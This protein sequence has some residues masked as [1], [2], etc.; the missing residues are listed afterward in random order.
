MNEKITLQ[1][2][3]ELFA[4]TNDISKKKSD[5]FL[6]HLFDAISE[7]LAK[8]GLVK[9][10]G[11]GTFKLVEVGERESI[12]VSTGE[13]VLIPGYKKVNFIPDELFANM[14]NSDAKGI[15]DDTSDLG[16]EDGDAD[17][18]DVLSDLDD[19]ISEEVE[20]PEQVE[21]A[22]DD[23]SGIDLLIST[24]ESV[25]GVKEDLWKARNVAATMRAKAEHAISQAKS[26]ESEVLRLEKLIELLEKK[27][28]GMDV[29]VGDVVVPLA[30][31][32]KEDVSTEGLNEEVN[33]CDEMR[34]DEVPED[35]QLQN[36]DDE[37]D[38]NL[39]EDN[40]NKKKSKIIIFILLIVLLLLGG[41]AYWYIHSD[42]GNGEFVDDVEIKTVDEPKMITPVA[43]SLEVDTFT[44]AVDSFEAKLSDDSLVVMEEQK[45]VEVDSLTSANNRKLAISDN[46]TKPASSVK[47]DKYILKEGETLTMLARR[48]YGSA[49]SVMAIINAN[50]FT[51]PNNVHVGAKVI[52]P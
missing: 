8:D 26:A 22:S 5:V 33:G 31:E 10:K 12:S 13:R 18:N 29:G 17:S 27:S 37:L 35:N 7:G 21:V 15:V 24:P 34:V 46:S 39:D 36:R 42:K 45:D 9:I 1:A 23:F 51:D 52:L 30:S 48:F 40:S 44:H 4:N 6:R 3:A 14:I 20:T 32:V 50:N 38:D 11:W 43:D 47:P 25:E 41:G 49:D 28:D 19:M 16:H 2:L